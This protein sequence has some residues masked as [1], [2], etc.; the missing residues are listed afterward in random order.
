MRSRFYGK[1][2]DLI[3]FLGFSTIDRLSFT[4]NNPL[5]TIL[6]FLSYSLVTKQNT[7]IYT[8][9]N[10]HTIKADAAN[11]IDKYTQCMD[12]SPTSRKKR[13]EYAP[14]INAL[15]KEAAALMNRISTAKKQNTDLHCTPMSDLRIDKLRSLCRKAQFRF[16]RRWSLFNNPVG[17]E[18]KACYDEFT[19]R[20]KKQ[21]K[22]EEILHR[23]IP[24]TASWM[25]PKNWM[26]F[27][28]LRIF[29]TKQQIE[30]LSILYNSIFNKIP[31]TVE[32]KKQLTSLAGSFPFRTLL[33]AWHCAESCVDEAVSILPPTSPH[34]LALRKVKEELAQ[35]YQTTRKIFYD[36]GNSKKGTAYLQKKLAQLKPGEKLSFVGGYNIHAIYYEFKR[37]KQSPDNAPTY[38]F[39]LVDTSNSN[40]KLYH[41]KCCS[42]ESN[43][44]E[45]IEP[46]RI[47]GIQEIDPAFLTILLKANKQGDLSKVHDA[48]DSLLIE[49]G[50]GTRKNLMPT[51]AQTADFSLFRK[52]ILSQMKQTCSHA[53]F[54]G[55]IIVK[56]NPTITALFQDTVQRKIQKELI[57]LLQSKGHDISP[58]LPSPE[59]AVRVSQIYDKIQQHPI[60][61]RICLHYTVSA[62]GALKLMIKRSRYNRK[63]RHRKWHLK[64]W[65]LLLSFFLQLASFA[66]A[67][68][69]HLLQLLFPSIP[70][71]L[72]AA[73]HTKL[74]DES[75]DLPHSPLSPQERII[76]G[77]YALEEL[78]KRYQNDKDK[79]LSFFKDKAQA[80]ELYQRLIIEG[81]TIDNTAEI[82]FK[83]VGSRCKTRMKKADG[84]YEEITVSN[85]KEYLLSWD[86]F[87]AIMLCKPKAYF[88]FIYN[89]KSDIDSE[90]IINTPN[91]K[92][93][94]SKGTDQITIF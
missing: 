57:L 18:I 9:L 25:K 47:S 17:N 52:T 4:R 62:K 92:L 3:T 49:K 6:T 87:A 90:I 10:T 16:G 50:R 5:N 53:S 39:T 2:R 46:L 59:L 65:H 94:L 70:T 36:I 31:L 84:T 51:I 15:M 28:T 74:A 32:E 40:N 61:R 21:E 83:I 73:M 45:I 8:I 30:L 14:R 58:D 82:S 19:Y 93:A 89:K 67:Q 72:A 7:T 81:Y 48:I 69:N 66:V 54:E 60:H 37:E 77:E 41:T 91:N 79:F 86:E 27:L 12:A 35:C 11:L 75:I 38:R 55:G 24:L 33:F 13:E 43:S 76:N 22:K 29:C 71:Y 64:P 23:H 56:Q 1:F 88:H 20:Y 34:L 80:E 44:H 78:R 42:D 63:L 68:Y 26:D 85:N